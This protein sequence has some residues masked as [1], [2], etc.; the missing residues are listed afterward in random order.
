MSS[1]LEE[2]S[3]EEDESGEAARRLFDLLDLE[4]LLGPAE[5]PLGLLVALE[6]RPS[7][8]A[9]ALALDTSSAAALASFFEPAWTG[10][11][12]LFGLDVPPCRWGHWLRM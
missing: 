3:E 1:G 4:L 7:V 2:E 5:A 9:A 10:S 6:A 12:C 11:T 8:D